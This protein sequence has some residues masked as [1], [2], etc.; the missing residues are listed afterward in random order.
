MKK[1]IAIIATFV[2]FVGMAGCGNENTNSQTK[3]NTTADSE[4]SNINE[5]DYSF[6]NS[7]SQIDTTN[8]N[9]S[10]DN[11]KTSSIIQLLMQNLNL[12]FLLSNN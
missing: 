5:S 9:E 7:D 4:H 8:R 1:I 2:L 12:C 3:I 10:V 11:I 6:T